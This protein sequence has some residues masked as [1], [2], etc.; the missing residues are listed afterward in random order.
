M[1]APMRV[2][3]LMCLA[4]AACATPAGNVQALRDVMAAYEGRPAS[5]LVSTLGLPDNDVAL[6]GERTL[7]WRNV[8]TEAGLVTQDITC[9]VAAELDENERVVGT[10]VTSLDRLGQ[11]R[12]IGD[13][14]MA[15]RPY[16]YAVGIH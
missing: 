9:E 15:C 4:L 5:D 10:S 16:L 14:Y 12:A 8:Y 1:V 6:G 7:L 3:V 11:K 2:A 13:G